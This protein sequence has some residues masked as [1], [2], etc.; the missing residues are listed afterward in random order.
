MKVTL[1][2]PDTI[3][4]L[5][6]SLFGLTTD[7]EGKTNFTIYSQN[8]ASFKDGDTLRYTGKLEGIPSS[9]DESIIRSESVD[10]K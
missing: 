5:T 9:E 10:G 4:G 3:Q 2:I 6:L 1:D 8:Y 7:D